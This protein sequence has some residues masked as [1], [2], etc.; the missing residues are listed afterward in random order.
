MDTT[1]RPLNRDECLAALR[2]HSVGRIA[3]THQALPLIVPVNYVL[4][5]EAVLFRTETD[6]ALARGCRHSVVAFEIDD[7]T[8]DG[9]RGLSVHL[10]GFAELVDDRAAVHALQGRV[11][12]SWEDGRDQVV[13][14]TL[15]AVTGWVA[16]PTQAP[17]GGP[18]FMAPRCEA[19]ERLGA[20]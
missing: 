7:L 6:S 14:I 5:A 2:S 18:G 9:Q 19:G 1:V 16:I 15:G 20:P 17:A 11:T 10:V 3:V 13:G 4:E 12:G 8:V